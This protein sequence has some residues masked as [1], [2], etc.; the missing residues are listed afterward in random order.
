MFFNKKLDKKECANSNDDKNK[1][2]EIVLKIVSFV[3]GISKK[4]HNP[5]LHGKATR[6]QKSL[7]SASIF[8]F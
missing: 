6:V 4:C 3:G 8:R 7:S 2:V 5:M 1:M